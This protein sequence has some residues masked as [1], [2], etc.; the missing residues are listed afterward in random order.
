MGDVRIPQHLFANMNKIYRFKRRGSATTITQA[1]LTETLG[2]FQFTL[3]STQG[4]TELTTL[5]DSYRIAF[6]EVQFTPVYNM[7]TVSTLANLITPNLY[8]AIDYDDN[9]AP[10]SIAA[11]Q[12]FSTCKMS[13]F[14]KNQ[15]RKFTPFAAKAIYSGT[16]VA[17]GMERG[18]IDCN[19]PT[20]QWYGI[21][22]GIEPGATG[23]TNL[24]SWKVNFIYY[25]EMKF[26]R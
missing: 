15:T 26:S 11:L 7:A 4:N 10:A 24:Q 20:A 8:T 14:D 23:Q 9:S 22:Y 18:W 1:A 17:F 6:I 19:S 2:S 12:E 21:K 5:F 3:S 16:F 13:R 25:I